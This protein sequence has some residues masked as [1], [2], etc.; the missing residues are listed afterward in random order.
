M[1]LVVQ[2]LYPQVIKNPRFNVLLLNDNLI[3]TVKIYTASHLGLN[4]MDVLEAVI[5]L[6]TYLIRYVF[7]IKHKF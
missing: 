5:L 6:M 3:N 4:K 7:E 2:N 1:P